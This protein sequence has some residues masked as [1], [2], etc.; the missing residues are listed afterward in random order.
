MQVGATAYGNVT[1]RVTSIAID[2]A[3]TTG[4]T[5]YLGTTGGGVWKSSNAAG[6]AANVIFLPLTDT[7]PVFSADSGN[8]TI[9]SLSIGALSVANGVIL[10]GTGDTNDSLDSYYGNGLL[11][12]A[13]GGLTWTLSRQS[14]D[15]VNGFHA[16]TGLGF[17]GIAWSTTNT[18]T[19]VAAVSD[20]VE[21]LLA[22]AEDGTYSTRGLYF[23]TDAGLTWQMATI[24]DQGQVVQTPKPV[25][26]NQGGNAATAVVWNPVRQRFYA[27][28]R[29]HGYY[30]SSDGSVWTRLVIQPGTGLTAS[31]CPPGPGMTGSPGCPIF[32]GTLAVEPMSGDTYA[33]TVDVLLHD[34]GLWRD[35]CAS[36]GSG[37]TSGIGFGTRLSTTAL[38][39]GPGSTAIFQGDYNLALAATATGTQTTLFAGTVDLFRCAFDTASGGSSGCVFRNTTNTLNGCSAPAMVAPAQHAI[40]AL[41]S[42]LLFLGNDGG[43][44]RSVDGV[45]EQGEP[46]SSNDAGHFQNLNGGLGPLAEVVSFAQHPSD[47]NTL[48]AGLG[49]NGTA[50]TSAAASNGIWPQIA[51]GEGGFAAI[52]SVTPSNWYVSTSAGVSIA[53]CANGA[54]CTAAD[55]S[56]LPTV[57]PAQV[58][59]DSSLIDAPWILDPAMPASVMIGT[60]RVWRGP[61]ADGSAWSA[62]NDL[63][64]DFGSSQSAVCSG[65]NPAVRSVA[66]GGPLSS[67]AAAN[68]G[69]KVLYAGLAGVLDGGG[70]LGG[71]IFSTRAADTANQ[72][73]GWT[74]ISL[75][76]VMNDAANGGAFNPGGFDISSVTIDSHDATGLTV[77]A[78]VMGFAGNGVLA[79]HV[80]RSTDGGTHWLNISSN[81][82]NAPANS[83]AVDPNDANTVYVALDTGVYVTQEVANCAGTNCWSVYGTSLPNAPVT[84][85]IASAAIPTGAGTL[86]MLR[87][88]TYG[89]GIWQTPLLSATTPI[90][91][92][93][94]LNPASLN[95][96]A[97]AVGSTSGPQ[98]ITLTNTGTVPL[99][100]SNLVITGD[101]HETDDCTGVSIA[102]NGSCTVQVTFLATATG[103]RSGVL[104]IYGN[105]AGGQATVPLSGIGAAPAAVVLNPLNLNFGTV[106]AGSMSAAQDLSVANTG[107]AAA[108]LQSPAVTGDFRMMA[109]TCGS[110]LPGNVGCTVSIAFAPASTGTRNGTLTLATST[111]TQTTSLTGVGSAPATDLLS[112]LSLNFPTQQYGTT[113]SPKTVTLTN[114]GDAA[115]TGISAQITDGEFTVVGN[116]ASSLIAHAACSFQVSFVPKSAGLLAGTLTVSDVVRSQT[117]ALSGMA[118]AP[119]LA[120]AA[121][122]PLAFPVTVIGQTSD[123]L[124]VTITNTGDGQLVISSIALTGDFTDTEGCTRT[125][126]KSQASCIIRVKFSP[127]QPGEETGTLTLTGN[128]AAGPVTVNL[129]G[130]GAVPAAIGLTPSSLDFGDLTQGTVSAVQNI[131]VSNTGG[132]AA[133]LQTPRVTTPFAI[134]AGTCGTSLAPNVGCTVSIVFAPTVSGKVNGAFTI[135][136]SAGV[137]TASLTGNGQT[138][139][140]D[141]LSPLALNFSPQQYGTA[142]ASQVVRLTNTGD[143]PLTLIAA[144][145]T[146]ADYAVVNNCGPKLD[147]HSICTLAV[148][149]SPLSQGQ[150]PGALTVSD[151]FRVQT[152]AL[153]GTGLAPPLA[154][155]APTTLG[156]PATIPG[157]SSAAQTVTVTNAG[158]GQ[159]AVSRTSTIGDFTATEGCTKALLGNGTSCAIQVA[160]SPTV[161][162]TASGVLTIFG[163]MPGGQATVPL[164]GKGVAAATIV[165]LPTSVDFGKITL[166]ASSQA[167]N[168]TISNTGGAA[169][170]LQTPVISGSAD[171]RVSA[172]T[173]GATLPAD[174]GCTVAIVFTPSASGVVNATFSI[175]D[176][177]GTQTASLTG[178][179]QSSATD[180]LSPLSLSFTLQQINT[181]SPAQLVTLTNTGDNALTLITAQ[182]TS[183]DF[184]ATSGCGVSLNGHGSCTIAV[185]SAPK[186]VGPQTGVLTV[187]DQFRVQTVALSGTG[188]APPGVSLS[189]ST[190]VVFP[191]TGVTTS[192]AAQ[193]VTLSNL[194]GAALAID[195]ITASGDFAVAVATNTCGSSIAPGAACTFQVVFTPILSGTRNGSI[196]V[197][198]DASGSPQT[199]ALQGTGVDFAFNPDGAVSVTVASGGSA[200]YP[201][202]LSSDAGTPGVAALTCSGAPANATCFV[203][204]S[205]PPLGSATII[206]VTVA[207][208][209]SASSSLTPEANR[210][211]WAGLMLPLILLGPL[212]GKLRR[213][214]GSGLRF[215][216]A[217]VVCWGLLFAG[218][219]GA[220]RVIPPPGGGTGPGGPSGTTTP[221][222]TYPITVSA[223]SA[224][225]TRSVQLTLVVR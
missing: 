154:V 140:S 195:A 25:G 95:F 36:S 143:Q 30:E 59:R 58:A 111:G 114:S 83:L 169:A 90:A 1:G 148:T 156:F 222:G 15:G 190:G 86:G 13:D 217:V 93:I 70:S 199:M 9:A 152:V 113:A 220:G 139:A 71:H 33:L 215:I 63:S 223:T 87:A 12:S 150:I 212:L 73:T 104:T 201:L 116:C 7:L 200:V 78:T 37:C 166:G 189:P 106:Q 92:V 157:Q 142:S 68:A 213:L 40:A 203:T 67:A 147:A 34:Q 76:P 61:A 173:C 17:A 120:T 145:T 167:Q 31:A 225:L 216:F 144:Q 6:P 211:W 64:T 117:V 84:S 121:P 133:S 51:N 29:Y 109:N 170:T 182:V 38:E 207:T 176:S 80:Y 14:N 115:L 177:T 180:G 172:S 159:L 89:R 191:A 108:T 130:T 69:S 141:A 146:A 3:D 161:V 47:A 102:V 204:P 28:V 23:S 103:A 85:L 8:A 188:T 151:Q 39:Q 136:T 18:S 185:A 110:V 124:P 155:L 11:R 5:V 187:S 202:L 132:V 32:R 175:A 27:A 101:F 158:G 10:A 209:V 198:D 97:Q 91:P 42:G 19:V 153:T 79:P 105:V 53:H 62:A 125:S 186:M 45:D 208:G 48:I 75:S 96:A 66:A 46:C 197:T 82:P 100:V 4:N 52:D 65:A 21:G 183:G 98:T 57:G 128:S 149:F 193:T 94:A 126:L 206:T 129:S 224:G 118:T 131:T 210:I 43:I 72:T 135:Q 164:A 50:A 26:G 55:F 218:G 181:A 194:G 123:S 192:S 2:P 205:G 22:N 134:S 35:V 81:L 112:P 60:C 184:T 163:N 138:P 99:V 20:A 196:S 119:P 41:G 16:F 54:A 174:T 44:W 179:G 77:Y 171:F 165:L 122:S 168:I 178:T 107:G 74:D 137:Q 219:C 127:T 49:A 214:N 88:G 24:R 160:F 162:G 56:G 221:S